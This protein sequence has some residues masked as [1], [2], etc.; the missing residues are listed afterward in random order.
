M[1]KKCR[2]LLLVLLMAVLLMPGVFSLEAE[3][4]DVTSGNEEYEGETYVK[5]GVLVSKTQ[6]ILE[7][8]ESFTKNFSV[9]VDAT[10]TFDFAGSLIGRYWLYVY[11]QETDELLYRNIGEDQ[12][13]IDCFENTVLDM[14]AGKYRVKVAVLEDGGYLEY[15]FSVKY[16]RVYT[17]NDPYYYMIPN[18]A[19]CVVYYDEP[20]QFAIAAK[21][22]TAIIPEV[23]W[24]V[25][26][27]SI[28]TVSKNGTVKVKKSGTVKLIA[29]VND[30]TLSSKVKVVYPKYSELKDFSL[31]VGKTKTLKMTVK[32]ADYPV[33]SIKWKSSKP[34][35]ATVSAK[36]VVTAKKA[37][38]ATITATV[39]GK[40]ISCVVTVKAMKINDKKETVYVGKTY[41]LKIY[42]GTGK[43]KWSS[44]KP[45]IAKVNADGKVTAVKPGTATITGKK[46][47]KSFSC[48]ITVKW[49]PETGVVKTKNYDL[50]NGTEP[51][52]YKLVL[53][54][55]STV[56]V[57]AK[58]NKG[59]DSLYIVLQ[60]DDYNDKWSEFLYEED[61]KFT[62]TVTLK[63]GTYYL[64]V[65]TDSDVDISVKITTKPQITGKDSKVGRKYKLNLKVAG[66]KNGGT[67]SSSDKSIATVSS[68]G[69]VK[70][71]KKGSCTIYY[72]MKDGKKLSYKIKV[73][74][75]VTC[76][77]TSI[78]DVEIY[79]DCYISF[80][81]YT[82]KDI[83]YIELMI[84]SYD[85]KDRWLSNPY[86][87]YFV[88]ET[89]KAGT[90]S[91]YYFWVHDNAS[92]CTAYITEVG[93]KDGT[94]WRP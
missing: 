78:S 58:V 71:V 45:E 65:S 20:I 90:E 25:S 87:Y 54:G 29:K 18:P 23:A 1:L 4:P 75:P 86:D 64:Y 68:K 73:V 9:P 40:K 7:E 28:A 52:N 77:V 92:R 51:K 8:Y 6:G 14:E 89:I 33:D 17:E 55:K 48:K 36:G 2:V 5:S 63:A 22:E 12:E 59:S 38:E 47:G 35:V 76:K 31:Y 82:N 81:N 34:A 60:D 83:K 67:W 42:G 46:N 53:N 15:A 66:V 13:G 44:N 79:N 69:V 3:M 39:N 19:E 27:T 72:T 70:G 61:G 16:E 24:S 57:T 74:D 88:D 50:P 10:V 26:D 37:G 21:P 85:Y 43:V 93:F 56:K 30:Q 84:N 80:K 49:E 32:P 91:E 62:K 94:Y 11:D 41:Q